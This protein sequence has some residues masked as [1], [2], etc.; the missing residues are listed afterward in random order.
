VG[1][2]RLVQSCFSPGPGAAARSPFDDARDPFEA[3]HARALAL[4]D[5]D[6]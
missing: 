6:P 3:A 2:V 4:L 1:A 5:G